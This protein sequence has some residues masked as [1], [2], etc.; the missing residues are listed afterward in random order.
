MRAKSLMLIFMFWMVS[1]SFSAQVLTSVS[2]TISKDTV[3]TTIQR[4]VALNA[5]T[6]SASGQAEFSSNSGYVRI[7]LTDE[8]GYDLLIYEST[9]LVATNAIDNFSNVAIESIDISTNFSFAKIRVE[10]KKCRIEKF[11]G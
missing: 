7:L 5:K 9:P 4:N 3:V 11:I 10:I 6:V 2:Q 8:Y 1:L